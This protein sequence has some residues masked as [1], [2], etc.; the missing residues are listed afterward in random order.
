[1]ATI[2]D[3]RKKDFLSLILLKYQF[4]ILTL[5]KQK[6]IKNEKAEFEFNIYFYQAKSDKNSPGQNICVDIDKQERNPPNLG[7]QVP[8]KQSRM[9]QNI[10]TKLL[11]ATA[12][13]FTT[14]CKKKNKE[15]CQEKERGDHIK[16]TMQ[17]GKAKTT[18][19]TSK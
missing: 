7:S 12:F 1:M 14:Q 8:A 17:N 9:S 11:I 3:S 2:K 15:L 4:S 5:N 10:Q 6:N 19:N 16:N 13:V 18:S